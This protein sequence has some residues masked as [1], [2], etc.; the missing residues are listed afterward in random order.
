MAQPGEREDKKVK[1]K[2]STAGLNG[3]QLRVEFT[4]KPMTAYGGVA[5][6]LGPFLRKV[7][8][9]EAVEEHW[10][11]REHSPNGGGVYEKF[12]AQFLTVLAGGHRFSHLLWW[13]HGAEVLG[14]AFSVSWLPSSPSSLTR[15][16]G[17]F[18]SRGPAESWGNAVRAMGS[19]IVAW[20]AMRS[21]DMILDSSVLTR[22]GGQEGARKGYNPEKPG[23]PSHHPILAA[24]GC[25]Y[26]VNLWNRSGDTFT[27]QSAGDFLDQ[28]LAALGPGFALRRVLCDSGFCHA[29][30]LKYMEG[31]RLRYIAAVRLSRA[32]Q[33]RILRVDAW[34]RV[35]EGI[36]VGEFEYHLKS[37]PERKRRRYLVVRQEVAKRPK[38]A[39]K[40]PSLFRD[41]EPW[42]EYRIGLFVTNE[43]DLAPVE[44]W[45]AYRLRADV[46]NV[47][48]DLKEGYGMASFSKRGFWATE[49]VMVTNALV[50]HNLIHALTRLVL[51]P[52]P[53]RPQLKTIRP[54]YF[55]IPA[56]LG[57]AGG[58]PVLR[59][60]VKDRSF[61]ARLSYLFEK[62]RDW[63]HTLNCNAVGLPQGQ[64]M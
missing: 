62:L 37:D 44:V 60:G 10:P 4:S 22:Y 1:R 13:G 54:R 24:L 12:L 42:R 39:G 15:F 36:E 40:Q 18:R 59:L 29:P 38:A 56:V 47:I 49:A 19:T 14:K 55:L 25:G 17:K 64:P 3:K 41:M 21:D 11:F 8:L 7:G 32:M 28:A 33:R 46:E 52:N 9:R 30:F 2:Q 61:R 31:R 45:R 58:E 57:N 53:P 20:E 34:R 16:W 51:H 6:I 48:K 50:F 43:E 26:V 63:R 5:A 23:R 27:A 35:D